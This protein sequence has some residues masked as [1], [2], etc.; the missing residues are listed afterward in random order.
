MTTS[1]RTNIS[2][3]LYPMVNAVLFGAGAILVLSVPALSR[4][5]IYLLP[6]VIVIALIVSAPVAWLIAP[7]LRW[8]FWRRGDSAR[9]GPGYTGHTHHI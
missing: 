9:P 4:Y 7:R 5:A 3:L 8:R 6:A 1:T 2:A